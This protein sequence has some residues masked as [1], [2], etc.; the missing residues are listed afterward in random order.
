MDPT[1]SSAISTF[2]RKRVR[3]ALCLSLMTILGYAFSNGLRNTDYFIPFDSSNLATQVFWNRTPFLIA[4]IVSVM[5]ITIAPNK[6]RTLQAL[7]S[8]FLI[9]YTISNLLG[10]DP[11]WWKNAPLTYYFYFFISGLVM[12][13]FI[14]CGWLLFTYENLWTKIAIYSASSLLAA[15]VLVV[16]VKAVWTGL[17]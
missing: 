13:L 4:G 12:G 10:G 17:G 5:F 7:L 9:S 16:F 2:Q 15:K 6:W 8:V 11:G 1:D 14:L 3:D